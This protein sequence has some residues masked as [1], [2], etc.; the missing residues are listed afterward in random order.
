MDVLLVLLGIGLL[1]GG[2]EALVRG[3]VQLARAVGMSPLVIGLTVVSF[4][5]SCPELAST[6]AATL[7]DAPAVAFGNVVGSNIA[8]IGLILG[9][10]ALVWP[11]ATQARILRREVPFMLAASGLLFPLAA[12]SRIGRLEGLFLFSLL[13][14]FLVYLVWGVRDA[15]PETRQEFETAYGEKARGPWLALALVVLG[16]ALLFVGAESL[17]RGGLNLA[18]AFGIS[19]RVIGLSLVALGTSLPEL[20]ASIV[21]ALKK[22]GDIVLGNLIGSNIFNVLC[23]LGLTAIV[24]PVEIDWLASWPDLVV[25]LALSALIWPFLA[26]R[27]KLE[28]WEGFLLLGGYVTYMAVLFSF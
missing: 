14:V 9:C 21:A 12:D 4:G 24:R 27:M 6:L 2:G 23:I 19:E 1:Y 25:M 11:L 15:G 5:T 3:S 20:A 22:E 7:E 17:I 28:R 13:V 8:N 18:R 10:T 16:L 26:T